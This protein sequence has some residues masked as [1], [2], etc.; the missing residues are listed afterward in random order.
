[1]TD[2]EYMQRAIAFI[3]EREEDDDHIC[4]TLHNIPEE[5]EICARDCQ[6]LDRFCVLRFLEHYKE[7]SNDTRT[8]K[9]D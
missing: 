9:S 3:V 8:K 7:K 5:F 4:E 2:T 1:M 6:N